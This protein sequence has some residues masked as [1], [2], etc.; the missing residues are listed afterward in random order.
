MHF[1]I[2]LT[3]LLV[4]CMRLNIPEE[5]LCK[6][7]LFIK[8]F[9]QRRRIIYPSGANT[10]SMRFHWTSFTIKATLQRTFLPVLFLI[11]HLF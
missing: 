8:E 3:Q 9:V 11:L 6:G 2:M 5:I 1:N 10:L 4:I 7:V